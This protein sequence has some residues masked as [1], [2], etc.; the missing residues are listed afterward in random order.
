MVAPRDASRSSASAAACQFP[1][2][3]WKRAPEIQQARDRRAETSPA[4][5]QQMHGARRI[6][7]LVALHDRQLDQQRPLAR[8]AGRE[9]DLALEQLRDLRPVPFARRERAQ[10]GDR[11]GQ[12]R[13]ERHRAPVGLARRRAIARALPGP[14]A[15]EMQRRRIARRQPRRAPSQL[16]RQ[17]ARAPLAFVHPFQRRDRVGVA[18]IEIQ[19]G[20]RVAFRVV[21]AATRPQQ[22]GPLDERARTLRRRRR[23]PGARGLDGER[24]VAA[25]QR[26]QLGR[27]GERAERR[28]ERGELAVEA[29]RLVGLAQ[30]LAP[31]LRR[32]ARATPRD[33][34]P[35][36]W[37][38]RPGRRRAPPARRADPRSAPSRRPRAASAPPRRRPPDRT[39]PARAPRARR[40][41]RRRGSR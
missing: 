31:Q 41:P 35:R 9:T 38:L 16:L 2:A 19:R 5:L 34:S 11:L 21:A 6:A 27:I 33:R 14:P 30:V 23:H 28:A 8:R 24:E 7:Q 13:I 3:S 17:L 26:R 15:S 4:R 39:R 25:H 37:R 36:R 40:W 12:R 22:R 29:Q 10:R 1:A 20:E 32:G 18:R